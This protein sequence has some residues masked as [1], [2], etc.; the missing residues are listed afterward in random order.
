MIT[1]HTSFER[2]Y[3]SLLGDIIHVIIHDPRKNCLKN[4]FFFFYFLNMHISVTSLY[5]ALKF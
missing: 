3:F 2:L 5:A 4:L 1:Y